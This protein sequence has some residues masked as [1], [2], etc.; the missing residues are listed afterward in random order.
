MRKIKLVFVSTSFVAVLSLSPLLA[1]TQASQPTYVPLHIEGTLEL[2]SN[3]AWTFDAYLNVEFIGSD[4]RSKADIV[5][6]VDGSYSVD[7]WAP[8]SLIDTH[9]A[10]VTCWG[11][12]EGADTIEIFQSFID[13]ELGRAS[14]PTPRMADSNGNGAYELSIDHT[15]S[16]PAMYGEI[17]LSNPSAQS[18]TLKSTDFIALPTDSIDSITSFVR[19]KLQ[20]ATGQSLGSSSTIVPIYRWSRSPATHLQLSG[21][22]GTIVAEA[23]LRRTA[24]I[25][26]TTVKEVS[27]SVSIS[28]SSYPD[29]LAVLVVAPA[30]HTPDPSNTYGSLRRFHE[31][32]RDRYEG[33][34][35]DFVSG[36]SQ[37]SVH[38]AAGDYVVELWS[39]RDVNG[40]YEIYLHSSQSITSTNAA[41]TIVFN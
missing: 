3:V 13:P 27:L 28:E 33:L 37:H 34:N 35:P 22:N 26:I 5:A 11:Y 38:I 16:L 18:L 24:T 20:V 31:Q 8:E 2:P 6:S 32:D 4:F 17:L 7:M 21:P 23:L 36:Q 9:K 29:A 30:N 19:S 25:P 14:F 1:Y 39:S 10:R 12:P 15:L 41:P 40:E